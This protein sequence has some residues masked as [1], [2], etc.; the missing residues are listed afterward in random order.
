MGLNQ[1]PRVAAVNRTCVKELQQRLFA[2]G[3]LAMVN[4]EPKSECRRA[5][6]HPH[7]VQLVRHSHRRSS[8]DNTPPG[9]RS[10]LRVYCLAK[11]YEANELGLI[12]KEGLK[13]SATNADSCLLAER[14]NVDLPLVGLLEQFT[15]VALRR[16]KGARRQRAIYQQDATADR[17]QD[18]NCL[19]LYHSLH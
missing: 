15:Y 3:A 10:A 14:K 12:V 19:L 6:A 16:V 9:K 2:G 18:G 13:R 7:P 11:G 8:T 4:I 17:V 1:R 5:K